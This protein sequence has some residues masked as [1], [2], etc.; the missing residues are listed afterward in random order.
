MSEPAGG[1]SQE[2]TRPA[3]VG[4]PLKRPDLELAIS[5]VSPK[6]S[7]TWLGPR[8]I[9][10]GRAVDCDT[11]LPGPETSR[12]HAK[13]WRT[14]QGGMIRDAGS[15]NG[16]FVNGVQQL[17]ATL[18]AGDILRVG[19]GIGLVDWH[20]PDAIAPHFEEIF[21]GWFGGSALQPVEDHVR[22]AA[23]SNLSIVVRG[24]TGTGKESVCRAIHDLSKRTGPIVVL[25]C[26]AIAANLIE[27]ELFGYKK[28]AFSG[29]D[30]PKTGLVQHAHLGTLV[31][32]EVGDMPLDAQVKLLRVLQ[33]SEVLPIGATTPE[34][35]DLRV[36]AATHRNLEQLQRDGRFRE[37]LFHRLNQVTV[38]IPPLRDRRE[39]IVP[40]FL[41]ALAVARTDG[42]TLEPKLLEAL[43]LY[44][45]AG[46]A[47]QVV[48][49]AHELAALHPGEHLIF[50][51]L[52]KDLREGG[53]AEEPK[54]PARKRSPTNDEHARAALDASL[55]ESNGNL[56]QAAESMGISRARAYRIL[57][58]TKARLRSGA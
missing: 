48:A 11:V 24:E 5:W 18:E 21:P 34:R 8:R 58:G 45:W 36:V 55:A 2:Q 9:T 7:L 17:E 13:V 44:D 12:L 56:T 16:V 14:A 40:L 47:R 31:L 6:P 39:D 20:E 35:V 52:P 49:R 43:L 3:R 50:D 42:A 30:R 22:K 28:G 32:D 53:Y 1:H 23:V 54:L 26:A 51:Y 15:T 25:N 29:A 46:N 10:L 37:D 41:R 4:L 57:A 33:E 19:E 38:T 27:S